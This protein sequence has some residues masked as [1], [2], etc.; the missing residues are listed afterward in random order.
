MKLFSND[1]RIIASRILEKIS[2]LFDL[3]FILSQKDHLTMVATKSRFIVCLSMLSFRTSKNFKH[4]FQLQKRS[5]T[6]A[7]MLVAVF[8]YLS[9]C[10]KTEFLSVYTLYM[11]LHSFT[12]IQI[13]LHSFI[14]VYIHLHLF[15]NIYIHLGKPSIKNHFFCDKCQTSSDPPLPFV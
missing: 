3:A 9:V 14:F 2:T 7:L 13:H 10:F 4:C 5:S 12:H 11:H 6:I 8:V 15:T 1:G